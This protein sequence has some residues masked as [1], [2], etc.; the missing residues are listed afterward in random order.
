MPF[1]KR[2]VKLVDV[3]GRFLTHSATLNHT[4]KNFKYFGENTDFYPK[5]PDVFSR[6]AVLNAT[7]RSSTKSLVTGTMP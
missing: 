2:I 1:A 3:Y 4:Y 6:Y 7:S 5:P